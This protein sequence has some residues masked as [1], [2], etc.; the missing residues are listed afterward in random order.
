MGIGP[1][2]SLSDFEPGNYRTNGTGVI[3][4]TAFREEQ[5]IGRR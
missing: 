3:A 4:T 5:E 1:V 2:L